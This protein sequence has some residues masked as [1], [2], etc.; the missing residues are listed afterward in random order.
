MLRH[1]YPLLTL[2]P[3]HPTRTIHTPLCFLA[4]ILPAEL[5]L[6]LLLHDIIICAP[7][8][9]QCNKPQCKRNAHEANNLVKETTVRK[10]HGTVVE[11]LFHRV[12]AGRY[13]I[14]V[15]GSVLEDGELLVEV[16]REE[17]E[18]GDYGEDD[19]GHEGVGAGGKGRGEAGWC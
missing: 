17:G 16:A 12:V 4:D 1:S 18:Q 2:P 3:I 5:T 19:V 10:D 11:R 6:D 9:S 13:G 14:V 15:G 7:R 8:V